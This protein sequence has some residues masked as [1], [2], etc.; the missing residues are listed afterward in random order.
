MSRL[1]SLLSK[2]DPGPDGPPGRRELQILAAIVVVGVLVR[3]GYGLSLRDLPLLGDAPGFDASAR[4]FADGHPFWGDLPYGDAHPTA[5][6][7]PA[8]PA[9]LGV[10]YTIF[11][12]SVTAVSV[13]QALVCGT[14]VIVLTWLLA[15][16]LFNFQIALAAAGVIAIY[17]N[18]FQWEASLFVEALVLPLTLV[19][20]IIVLRGPPTTRVAIGV[21]ALLGLMLLVRP[22]SFFLLAGLLAAWWLM[23][24]FREAVRGLAIAAVCM[25]LVVLP[26]T[27]RN[28]IVLDGFIPISVQDAAAAG[29]FNDDAANDEEYPYAWRPLASR[30]ADLADPAHPLSEPEFRSELQSRALDYVREHPDAVPKAIFWNGITRLWDIRRP[31]HVVEEADFQTRRRSIAA[32]GLG[33]YYVLAPLALV[34]LW[35]VRRSRRTLAVMLLA[36]AAAAVFV[37]AITATTRYRLPFEPM[38]VIL[39]CAAVVP[40]LV[41]RARFDGEGEPAAPVETTVA[42]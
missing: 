42:A 37:F 19:F 23:A 27:V 31:A 18:A 1:R 10:I 40:A 34:G 28:A 5:W 25:V 20:F 17:A 8:Y 12:P 7:A 22:T 21:G 29:T 6:K 2:I 26:W 24:G 30:D 38:I 36:M 35:R 4:L 11:G 15:R 3:I 9:W 16:R 32:L 14:T 39:A 41:P 13:V 33:M